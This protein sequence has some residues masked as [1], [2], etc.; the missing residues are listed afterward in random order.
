MTRPRRRR[1]ARC[2]SIVPRR[3]RHR[4]AGRPP[5]RRRLRLQRRRRARRGLPTARQPHRSAGA[6]RRLPL[7]SRS[8]RFPA[9]PRRRQHA[10]SRGWTP[11]APAELR[12]GPTYVHGDSAGGNLALVA[13]L[14]HPGRFARGGADL[15][16]PRPE[17]RLRLLPHRG[18]RLRPARGR[19]VLAA[20][21]RLAGRPDPSGP[22]P[23]A[24]RPARHAA[25]DPGGD[26][27]ARP[28]ARRGRAPRVRLA[29]E[30]GVEVVATRYLGQVH[31]FWRH[32]SVFPAAEALL[33][34]VGGFFGAAR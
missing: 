30:A 21:R 11:T 25:A 33:R 17:R 12:A 34:Q 4:R 10:W 19:L 3:T 18:R 6:Q 32:T 23:A 27:R 2:G 5:A 28:A 7:R 9:A 31:G 29:V 15:P 22:R 8:T 13:A 20:V 26:R 16:V 24:L 14:R 1:G